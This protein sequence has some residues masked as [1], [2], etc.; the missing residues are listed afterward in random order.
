MGCTRLGALEWKAFARQEIRMTR[1]IAAALLVLGI[2]SI[3]MPASA[4]VSTDPTAA[5][6]IQ[7]GYEGFLA[8][9]G[10]DDALADWAALLETPSLRAAGAR[11]VRAIFVCAPA[12]PRVWAE[13]METRAS[14][15]VS[16]TTSVATH[17]ARVQPRAV[18]RRP[19]VSGA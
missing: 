2:A 11:D 15:A 4:Q 18:R 8:A 19:M 1:P 12:Q 14:D 9:G 13:A 10:F 5:P 16:V 6:E 3:V 7:H 17:S